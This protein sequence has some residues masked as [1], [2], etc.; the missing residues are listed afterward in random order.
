VFEGILKG[1]REE[2]EGRGRGK[3]RGEGGTGLQEKKSP[4]HR[5]VSTPV[6]PHNRWRA[7]RMEGKEGKK[8]SRTTESTSAQQSCLASWA[9]LNTQNFWIAKEFKWTTIDFTNWARTSLTEGEVRGLKKKKRKG[10]TRGGEKEE[11]GRNK[12]DEAR[13]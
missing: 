12:R 7:K 5:E 13:G 1:F 6:V 3:E 4:Y 11:E 9:K 10:E 2:G 8:N